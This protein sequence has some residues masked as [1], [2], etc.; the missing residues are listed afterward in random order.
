MTVVTRGIILSRGIDIA[1]CQN[2]DL[3][4]G[5]KIF[6]QKKLKKFKKNLKKNLKKFKKKLKKRESDTWPAVNGVNYFFLKGT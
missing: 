5:N 4:R 6:L 1:T 3:T 2:M